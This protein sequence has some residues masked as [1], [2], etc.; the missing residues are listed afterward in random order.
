M[1]GK[2]SQMPNPNSKLKSDSISL[3]EEWTTL[4][5]SAAE[6]MYKWPSDSF[7]EGERM[8]PRAGLKG[9]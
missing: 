7:K 6:N 1:L 2:A 4:L 3:W 9:T 5:H 8:N